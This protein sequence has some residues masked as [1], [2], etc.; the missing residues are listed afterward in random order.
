MFKGVNKVFKKGADKVKDASKATLTRV[1]TAITTPFRSE[2][3]QTEEGTPSGDDPPPSYTTNIAPRPD[4]DNDESSYHESDDS[5]SGESFHSLGE[6]RPPESTDKEVPTLAEKEQDEK[7]RFWCC[8]LPIMI[9]LIL[10]MV[11]LAL[12][13]HGNNTSVSQSILPSPP[14]QNN[15]SQKGSTSKEVLDPE[16][17]DAL[18]IFLR[19]CSM[20]T[21]SALATEGTPQN[22][23]LVWLTDHDPAQLQ[24]DDCDKSTD[25]LQRYTLAVLY[26]S[27]SGKEENDCDDDEKEC[28]EYDDDDKLQQWN[29]ADNWFSEENVCSWYGAACDDD[30]NAIVELNLSYNNLR[31]SI[32]LE[33]AMLSLLEI[34]TLAG[35]GLTGAIPATLAKIEQLS[36]LALYAN[37][38]TGE[39]PKELFLHSSLTTLNA[40]NNKLTGPLPVDM[41]ATKLEALNLDMNQVTGKIPKSI[42]SLPDLQ[43]LHLQHNELS[44]S[45]P[46]MDTTDESSIK[47]LQLQ[48]NRLSGNILPSLIPKMTKLELLYLSHNDFEGELFSTAWRAL[49][50]LREVY[51]SQN[52][53]AGPIPAELT[54]PY[55]SQLKVLHLDNNFFTGSI[56]DTK[57][58]KENDV[59]LALKEW[60]IFWNKLTGTLPSRTLWALQDSLEDFQFHHQDNIT[61]VLPTIMGHLHQLRQLSGHDNHLTGSIPTQLGNLKQLHT[62]KLHNNYLQGEFPCSGTSLEEVW[63]DCGNNGTILDCDCCTACF[64]LSTA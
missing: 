26:F 23:A 38:L 46:A 6:K 13:L 19:K 56:P 25:L 1:P 53:L 63:L 4:S 50:N 57:T 44:G 47:D 31:G 42:W 29:N 8:L 11:V 33:L 9:M 61:G 14:L 62:V 60:Y 18:S 2:P 40:G 45:L 58:T 64:P 27:T 49:P 10:L 51:L 35:N 36:F 28:D 15:T 12:V 59:R 48:Y 3:K 52:K 32:P 22:D 37:L 24:I 41:N 20:T 17:Y 5:Y 16:R 39:I 54:S 43:T 30:A 7:D 34:L 21:D 55:L